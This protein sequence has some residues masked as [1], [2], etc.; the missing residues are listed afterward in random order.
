MLQFKK[1]KSAHLSQL[2][3]DAEAIIHLDT[4]SRQEMLQTSTAKK[5]WTKLTTILMTITRLKR[6]KTKT[7]DDPVSIVTLT[8]LE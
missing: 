7:L 2:N 1:T 8:F 3:L 6:H 5:R 4:G